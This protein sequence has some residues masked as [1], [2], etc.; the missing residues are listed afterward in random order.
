ME[1]MISRLAIQTMI[2]QVLDDQRSTS[3]YK[4]AYDQTSYL[5][6]FNPTKKKKPLHLPKVEFTGTTTIDCEVV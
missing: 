3:N 4:Y 1:E 6:K 2:G 5:K